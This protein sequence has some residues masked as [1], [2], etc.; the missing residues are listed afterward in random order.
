MAN[1]SNLKIELPATPVDGFEIRYFTIEYE[2]VQEVV[3]RYHINSKWSD[4]CHDSD[5]QGTA[6]AAFIDDWQYIVDGRFEGRSVGWLTPTTI[7]RK[8]CYAVREDATAALKAKL[9]AS[10]DFYAKR[11]QEYREKANAI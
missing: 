2:R 1:S 7:E 9:M 3:L 6:G 10:A 5:G 8:D 4:V 11:T